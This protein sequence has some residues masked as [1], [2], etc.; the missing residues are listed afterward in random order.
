MQNPSGPR[1]VFQKRTVA[2]V[3]KPFKAYNGYLQRLFPQRKNVR[4]VVTF[5]IL[6][7]GRGRWP[8]PTVL[9]SNVLD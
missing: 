8:K 1:R 3:T 6:C 4:S 5:V 9:F 7:N 2:T